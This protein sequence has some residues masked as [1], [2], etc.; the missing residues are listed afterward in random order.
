MPYRSQKLYQLI[1]HKETVFFPYITADIVLPAAWTNTI[2][3]MLDSSGIFCIAYP[4]TTRTLYQTASIVS[5]ENFQQE[6]NGAWKLH[7]KCLE[8]VEIDNLKI[9][10]GQH[11]VRTHPI[12]YTDEKLISP[13]EEKDVKA[14][15]KKAFKRKFPDMD[16]QYSAAILKNFNIKKLIHYM[17]FVA[18]EALPKKIEHLSENSLLRLYSEI[19]KLF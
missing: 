3:A 9:I 12:E 18:D 10:K 19:S 5:I 2:Q 6:S 8:R 14:A 13:E 1:P 16:P 4:R 17:C 7:L 15:L 11:L